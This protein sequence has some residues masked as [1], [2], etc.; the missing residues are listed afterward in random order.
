MK[1]IF[2]T[3]IMIVMLL[4]CCF[5]FSACGEELVNV[6]VKF[7]VGSEEKT[8]EFVLYKHLAPES[9]GQFEELAEKGYYND[10]IMYK[11][12]VQGSAIAI[13]QYKSTTDG[14][15]Y[16]DAYDSV[17]TIKG[18]FAKGGTTGSNLYAN[19]GAICVWRWWDENQGGLSKS[20]YDTG[21]AGGIMLPLSSSFNDSQIEG[22]TLIAVMGHVADADKSEY[23]K[24][25]DS[26]SKAWSDVDEYHVFYILRD[27]ELER[28]I[29]TDDEYDDMVEDGVYTETET[30]DNELEEFT[31]DIIDPTDDDTAT[32]YQ[33]N[34][35]KN[36]TISVPTKENRI[37]VVSVTIK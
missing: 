7:M 24:I 36:A 11:S 1:K 9:V 22:A 5:S 13:G 29:L 15:A 6:E 30:I 3:M 31:Y 20:G 25:V 19:K 27:G 37:T 21:S 32:E 10:L 26:A 4:V 33:L 34:K 28:I 23:E 8:I 18:E 12:N 16:N 14:I 2:S 35:Y 17:A